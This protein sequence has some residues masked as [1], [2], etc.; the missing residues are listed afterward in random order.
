MGYEL[1]AETY[2]YETL[3]DIISQ[4][5]KGITVSEMKREHGI[6]GQ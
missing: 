5:P 3:L 6:H 4:Q 2:N 1:R